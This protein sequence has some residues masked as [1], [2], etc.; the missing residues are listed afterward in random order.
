MIVLQVGS[1]SKLM[2]SEAFY[3]RFI[4]FDYILVTQLDTYIFRDELLYWCQKGYDYIGAPWIPSIYHRLPVSKLTASIKAKYCEIFNIP[5]SHDIHYN[6][7]NGGLSLRKVSSHLRAVT[8]LPD[9]INYFIN[10]KRNSMFHEDVFFSLEVN[11]HGSN[12]KYPD[13]KEALNFSFD[14]HPKICFKM[15]GEKLPFGCHGWH[16]IRMQKFWKQIITF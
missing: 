12:F 13:F 5:N 11:K 4:E 16:K 8:D 10:H 1:T 3:S 15:N 9:V 2:M 7:G 14:I 6:V